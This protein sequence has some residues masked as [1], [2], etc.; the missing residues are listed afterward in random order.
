MNRSVRKSAAGF[1]LVEML[2]A[3]FLS[4]LIMGGAVTL[5]KKGVDVTTITSQ[6]A[7]MQTDLRA[8][9]DMIIKDLS[10][11]GAGMWQGGIAV[12][13][14]APAP[15]YGCDLAGVCYVTATFPTFP[16]L[17]ISNTAYYMLAGPSKGPVIT[18]GQPATDTVT[19]I[20][21]DQQFLLNDYVMTIN[22]AGTGATFTPPAIIPNPVPQDVDDPVVGLR[23][24]DV[25][26]LTTKTGP[27]LVTVTGNVTKAGAGAATIWTVPFANG[28]ILHL[29]NSASPVGV[30]AIKGGTNQSATRVLIITYYIDTITDLA[31]NV[32]P[33]LMRQVNTQKPVPLADNII[34][35]KLTYDTYDDS[36]VLQSELP[37][38]GAGS[39]PAITPALIQKVNLAAL[40]ART[41][42]R[43]PM[44]FQGLNLQTQ[45]SVRNLSFK[46]RYQ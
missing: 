5:F 28:D 42:T 46:N 17:G 44:G 16:T 7:Q 38:A 33:R 4:A 3:V 29:N 9:E 20:Y 36:G 8:A 31:G 25:L 32:T 39:T 6:R 10:M 40:T 41:A 18:V 21:A 19:M 43:G 15:R 2:M 35:L 12:P 11:A 37:D 27:A 24:G 1:T 13:A 30:Q 22:A 23:P 14:V 45:V 26:Q 34:N